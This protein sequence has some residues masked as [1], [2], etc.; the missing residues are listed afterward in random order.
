MRV[1]QKDALL[2][3]PDGKLWRVER[4]ISIEADGIIMLIYFVHLTPVP[5]V[6][7]E[8]PR[9]RP[10]KRQRQNRK[11]QRALKRERVKKARN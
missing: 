5:T 10:A 1:P 2:T 11:M 4:I 6:A 7:E 9:P 8:R 3:R